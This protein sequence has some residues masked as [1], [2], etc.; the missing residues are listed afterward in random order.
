[1]NEF[2]FGLMLGWLLGLA[3]FIAGMFFLM[4]KRRKP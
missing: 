3:G 2:W 4:K 1:M